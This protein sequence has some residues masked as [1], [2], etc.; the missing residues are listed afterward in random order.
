MIFIVKANC[1][2]KY[3]KEIEIR[4]LLCSTNLR[5]KKKFIDPP[6]HIDNTGKSKTLYVSIRTS[7]MVNHKLK[8]K[9]YI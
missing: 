1:S 9:T 3:L 7:P 8:L 2:M 6:L 5:T 4:Y